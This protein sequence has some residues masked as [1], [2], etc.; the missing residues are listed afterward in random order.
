MFYNLTVI[1]PPEQQTRNLDQKSIWPWCT[2]TSGKKWPLSKWIRIN[3]LGYKPGGVKVAVWSDF[4][5][6]RQGNVES[7]D[8]RSR[9]CV[10]ARDLVSVEVDNVEVGLRLCRQSGKHQDRQPQESD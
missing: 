8:E 4:G 3:Y 6:S 5:P 10:M 9:T 7:A 1:A 2:L